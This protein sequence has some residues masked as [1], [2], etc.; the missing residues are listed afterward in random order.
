MKPRSLRLRLLGLA[1][2][3]ISLALLV[4][5]IAIG[6]IFVSNVE[7]SVRADLVAN[8]NRLV[9]AIDPAGPTLITESPLPNP[10]YDTPLSGAYWQIEEPSTQQVWRSQSLLDVVL[11]AS[12]QAGGRG[13]ETFGSVAGPTEDTLAALTREVHFGD[14]TLLVTLAENRALL[15]ESIRQF[16]SDLL[17]ALLLLGVALVAAAG[18][19]VGLGLQ[20][21]EDLRAKL[22]AVRQ[23]RLEALPS[24][25]PSEIQPLA[26][27]VNALLATQAS[28]VEFAR[29]RAADLAHGLKTPL[30]VM[31]TLGPRLTEKGDTDGAELLSR[32]IDEM[33]GRVAYQLRLSRLRHRTREHH[34]SVPLEVTV[35]T[36]IEVL[37]R[38]PYGE[39]LN[40]VSNV[41][42]GV[43]VDI[44]RQ[45]LGELVGTILENAS[46]WAMSEVRIRARRIGGEVEVII[47]DDGPGLPPQGI[48]ELGKRGQ[49]LDE[50]T[51]GSGLGISIAREIVAINGGSISF[52]RADEGGLLVRI[53]L[54]AGG[55]PSAQ[56]GNI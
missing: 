4:A 11:D 56:N 55:Q 53:V 49:R 24:D 9:A 23:G 14:R 39:T 36:T 37:R 38:T 16:G 52:G 22:G 15:D 1:A 28:T 48:S 47:S 33:N 44:D 27:E 32:L 5:G 10:R 19:Q 12:H 50:T 17:V 34:L 42:D 46:K 43:E 21:L 31:R 3:F 51:D 35:R 41:E 25:Y 20:P 13:A 30:T 7:R 26:N 54:V 18:L 45:D 2:V 29:A 40:W 6:S 8:L